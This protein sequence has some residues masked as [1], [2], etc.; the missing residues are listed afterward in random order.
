MNKSSF[1]GQDLWI[2]YA[3]E[4][5]APEDTF[6]KLNGRRTAVRQRIAELVTER[7]EAPIRGY[8]R[9][10][11]LPT[12]MMTTGGLLDDEQAL[13]AYDGCDDKLKIDEMD[14]ESADA[15]EKKEMDRR[16]SNSFPISQVGGGTNKQY[17][18]SLRCLGNNA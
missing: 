1:F 6:L 8:R 10:A 4:Y 5:E 15:N 13:P 12:S 7:P 18:H 9:Q 11:R 2:Q 16:S 3:P 14:R 17:I